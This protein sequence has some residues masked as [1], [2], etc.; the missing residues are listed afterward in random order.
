LWPATK[1]SC[2]GAGRLGVPARAAE[3]T[4]ALKETVGSSRH[5]GG[6]DKV[7][8][9]HRPVVTIKVT[10][11]RGCGVPKA[12]HLRKTVTRSPGHPVTRQ[13]ARADV[14]SGDLDEGM[15]SGR[16]TRWWRDP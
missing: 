11:R 1:W 12:G 5:L 2:P 9:G 16:G 13:S 3:P 8:G 7:V 4:V 14:A 10:T 15:A 6:A